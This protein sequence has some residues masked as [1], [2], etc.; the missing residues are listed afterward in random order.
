MPLR[1]AVAALV[2]AVRRAGEREAVGRRAR[3]REI[4]VVVERLR[5]VVRD[6][7]RALDRAA[8]H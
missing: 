2:G 4:E 3:V 7:P 1:A 6:L 8:G 5:A